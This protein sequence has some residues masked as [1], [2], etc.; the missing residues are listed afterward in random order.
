MIMDGKN[1][2]DAALEEVRAVREDFDMEMRGLKKQQRTA[3]EKALK[4]VDKKKIGK[5]KKSFE[6]I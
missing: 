3:V 1:E 4:A 6:G 2:N 5:I